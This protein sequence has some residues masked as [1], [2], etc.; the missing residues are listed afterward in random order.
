[1]WREV[2]AGVSGSEKLRVLLSGAYLAACGVQDLRRRRISLRL[3][4]AAG[5]TAVLLDAAAFACGD[6]RALSYAAGLVPGLL[7]LLLAFFADGAAGQGDGICFLVLGAFLGGAEAW[8][9]LTAAL[10]LASLSGTGLMFF[11][12]AGRKTRLPFLTIAAA[13]WAGL[14]LARGTGIF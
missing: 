14:L 11:R 2:C 5:C 12:K 6:G 4:L 1:M 8:T 3:S 13:A 9:V 10:I 7:L